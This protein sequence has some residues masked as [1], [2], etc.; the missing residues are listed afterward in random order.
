MK[1]LYLIEFVA[2]LNTKEDKL[3]IAI[4]EGGWVVQGS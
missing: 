4:V 1:K 2:Y 3:V